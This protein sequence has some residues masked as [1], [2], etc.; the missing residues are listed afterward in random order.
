M[1][2]VP[3]NY[4]LDDVFDDFMGPEKPHHNPMKCDVY[5]KDGKYNI[6]V[7]IP[8][9]NK[10][11]V[12]IEAKDGYLTIS[13]EKKTEKKEDNEEKKYFY[14]E[15]RYGKVERSFYIGDMDTDKISAKME[16]GILKINIP[17][18]EENSSKK[19]IEIE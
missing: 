3:R 17:K 4:F 2:I 18:I 8:G 14:H 5:E 19:T 13:A 12:N 16:N 15:R 9:Y 6:E 7:D 11:E 1:K 10:E